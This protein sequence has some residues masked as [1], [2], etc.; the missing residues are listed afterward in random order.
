MNVARWWLAAIS[1]GLALCR[2]ADA[3]AQSDPA[4]EEHPLHALAFLDG[5]WAGEIDGTLG[6]T[7]GRR[8]YRFILHD[9]F[10]HM[11]HD[12]DPQQLARQADEPDEWSIFSF[13]IERGTIVLRE[14]LVEGL[15]NTYACDFDAER[16]SLTCQSEATEGSA[17]L[18]LRLRYEF[19]DLDHFSERFEIFGPDGA[20]QVRMDGQ[21]VR[22]DERG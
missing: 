8:Q 6:P 9:R 7:T 18:T 11:T 22:M 4:S 5:S 12:R 15:V 1:V 17:G 13:D 19:A 21:W 2:P 14:F 3:A 20:L 16:P 10:L